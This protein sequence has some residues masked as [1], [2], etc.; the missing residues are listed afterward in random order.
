MSIL[1]QHKGGTILIN[2]IYISSTLKYHNQTFIIE[3]GILNFREKQMLFTGGCKSF[4]LSN[5]YSKLQIAVL[6]KTI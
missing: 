2:V 3:L 6:R 1:L 5:L 4:S